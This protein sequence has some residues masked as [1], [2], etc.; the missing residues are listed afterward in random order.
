MCSNFSSPPVDAAKHTVASM[1]CGVEPS[2]S[3][4]RYQSV[5]HGEWPLY[6]DKLGAKFPARHVEQCSCFVTHGLVSV[7]AF[8][9]LRPGAHSRLLLLS[10]VPP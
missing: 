4:Q 1:M 3:G 10:S 5:A 7:L 8:V 6:L 9:D 2:E